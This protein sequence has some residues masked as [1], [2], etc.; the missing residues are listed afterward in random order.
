[1]DET[2]AKARIEE[3]TQE[4]NKHNYNYYILSQPLISDFE[5]DALLKELEKLEQV[6]PHLASPNSPSQK[7]GGDIT[8]EFVQVYH[9]YPMLSLGNT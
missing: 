2:I 3:L 8:K 4:L 7:V 5:F 1:M 6:F 9:K